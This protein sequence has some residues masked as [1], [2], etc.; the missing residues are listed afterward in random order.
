MLIIRYLSLILFVIAPQV[1][2]AQLTIRGQVRSGKTQEVLPF[3][4]VFLSSTTK[5]TV[6]NEKGQFTLD[7]VPPGRFELIVSYMGF[8]T[9][10]VPVQTQ[11]QKSYKLLLKP[12]DNQLPDVTVKARRRRDPDR[13][14]QLALFTDHFIGLSENAAQCRLIN[15]EVLSFNQTTDRLIATANEPLLID[16][17]ALGYRIKF[18]L[19]QFIYEYDSYQIAYEGNPVFEAMRPVNAKESERWAENRK[20]AYLGS[21][22]H[23]ARALYRRQVSQEGF[24]FQRVIERKNRSGDLLRIGLPGNTTVTFP[25]LSN[26]RQVISLPMAS[27]GALLDTIRSTDTQPVIAFKGL[28][29]VT[30]A[31][32]REPLTFQKARRFSK[33]GYKNV[34]QSSLIRLL[35]P[36][37]T[38]EANGQFWPP[39]G[40]RSEGYWSW[41]L[42]ADDLPFDYE[43]DAQ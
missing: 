40:I 38:V 16:N 22:M 11:D 15:P 39:Q 24:A 26:D 4:T 28:I 13:A 8:V 37:L 7:N 17:K 1:G 25:S 14:K 6:T 30:Y 31:K 34:P 5:G 9:L 42:V 33:F 43:P 12:S 35:K 20:K 29:H 27:Y 2:Q 21:M 19:D 18:Q 23:F 32:E 36:G 3:A 10:K 41:E